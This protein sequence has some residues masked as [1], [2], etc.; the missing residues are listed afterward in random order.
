MRAR[1]KLLTL[2]K[3]A[4]EGMNA[5]RPPVHIREVRR[6]LEDPGAD[7]GHRAL[8]WTGDRTVIV[9]YEEHERQIDVE[10]VSCTRRRLGA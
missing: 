3:H 1:G 7:D 9:Y 10:S 4:F 2:S 5:E 8:R 6:V